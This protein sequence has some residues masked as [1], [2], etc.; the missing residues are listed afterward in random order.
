MSVFPS[1]PTTGA[2]IRAMDKA[3][4]FHSWSAQD[5]I[6]PVPVKSASGAVF[7]DYEGND[8]LDFA[9]QLVYTNLGHQHPRLVSAIKDQ[10]DRLVTVAPAFANDARSQLAAM[11]AAVAPG[12]LNHVFFTN[13]GAEANENAVRM[14]RVHTG[15][16]KVMSMYRSYHG[17]TSTAISMTGDPRRWANEPSDSS[18]VH[19]FGPYDYRSPFYSSSPQE[20]SDRALEQLEQQI[21]LEGAGTIAAIIMETVVGTNGILVPPPGYLAGVR[22]ICDRYGIVYIA[23]E[24]MAGFG[25]TGQWFAVDNWDV[26]PDLISFAKGV[27]SGYV[28]LGGVVISD[29]IRETFAHR[30]FPGGLTYSGHP[31]A[32]AVGVESLRVMEDDGVLERVRDLGERVVRPFVED[33]A[34]RHPVVGAVR[35]VGL[36]WAIELVRDRESREPLVPFNA[37]G[38]A[39][40]PMVE[41]AAACKVRGLWPFMHFNRVHVAPPLVISEEELVRGLQITD[42]ALGLLDQYVK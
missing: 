20:E 14:A 36:F 42:E 23:D 39:N 13:G 17:S 30:A 28:P 2:E 5:E 7:T 34:Q 29:A 9:S 21:I 31:L 32:C 22:E 33:L 11:I 8:Y 40:A 16:R 1:R 35:G 10:A 19:F 4:V 41:F 25:R 27:N 6:A 24:V 38:E 18:V 37:A 15:R 26:T 3:H 12:D